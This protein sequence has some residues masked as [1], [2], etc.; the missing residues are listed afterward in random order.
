MCVFDTRTLSATQS[1]YPVQL[2]R[3]HPVVVIKNSPM[4]QQHKRTHSLIKQKKHSTDT[5]TETQKKKKRE[6]EKGK[7]TQHLYLRHIP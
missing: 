7:K 6:P 5:D 1:H 3:K 4:Q 2:S